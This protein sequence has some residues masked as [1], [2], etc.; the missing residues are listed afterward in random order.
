MPHKEVRVKHTIIRTGQVYVRSMDYARNAL[1]G[2]Y[3]LGTVRKRLLDGELMENDE[4]KFEV[5]P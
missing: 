3:P 2:F 1:R 5:L 4:S